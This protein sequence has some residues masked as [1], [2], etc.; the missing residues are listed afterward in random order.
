MDPV[1]LQQFVHRLWD[2]SILPRLLEY[3][4]IPNKSPLFD[5]Q[6]QEHGFM[7]QAV[8]LAE[9][10]CRAQAVAG[11]TMEVVRLPGR[12]PVLYLDIAGG[13]DG[14]V[15]L[16]GHLDKQPEMSGWRDGLGPWQPVVEGDRLYGR[17]G[18]DDGYAVF[19]SVA[20]VLALQAQGIP[21]PH[22]VAII[23][24]CEESGS[25]DLPHYIEL[26]AGRIGTPQLVVCLDSG[27]GNYD[28]LWCT[29]SLRGLVGGA[30]SVQILAEGVHSSDA[31][32]VVPSSFRILRAVLSRLEDEE[33]GAVR[34]RAFHADIPAE[35]I[36]QARDAAATLGNTV[37]E[38]FPF[39]SGARPVDGKPA[40]LI[41][42]RTWRPALAITGAAGLPPL[43]S[44][45]NVLRPM[46]ACKVSLRLPPTTDAAVATTRLKALLEDNPPY[47]ASVR[48]EPEQAASG[49]HAPALSAALATAIEAASQ[50]HFGKAAAYIG[51]GG[52][53]PFMGMLGR[54]FPDAQFII[55]G[56]LGPHSNAHGPNE[57][58]HIPTAKRVT[59][60]VAH[61]IADM[62]AR[63]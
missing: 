36:A 15:L 25:Y 40:E 16:Y 60:C 38:R 14:S 18:A 53:I 26:L 57:F 30:L 44:A 42:N 19:A 37:Y 10:W 20:A 59:C 21:H 4:R 11:M 47:G 46:T 29:T 41:L 8:S 17:G 50:L 7:D 2:D 55:T 34:P 9:A 3:I 49:W 28:Q 48:F 24:C 61:I 52:S 51:E 43:A 56:V 45:G 13:T 22:C 54:R 5:P 58:L 1:R 32:G 35:R 63:G 12:T 23:E 6:W 27:C 39:V 62:G 31:S 33:T